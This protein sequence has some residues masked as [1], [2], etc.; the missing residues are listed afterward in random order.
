MR[1]GVGAIE[2]SGVELRQFGEE[3][4]INSLKVVG[5]ELFNKVL[6]KIVFR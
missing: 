3:E 5:I 6:G 1:N 4:Q 2:R